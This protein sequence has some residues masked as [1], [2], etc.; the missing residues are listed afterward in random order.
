MKLPAAEVPRLDPDMSASAVE[1]LFC[2][3][4]DPAVLTEAY[5]G[6]QPLAEGRFR[7]GESLGAGAMGR[8]F[9][10]LD[11]SSAKEVAVKVMH[12]ELRKD[13]A[14]V[15][16]FRDEAMLL[17]RCAHPHVVA[18]IAA[19]EDV[20][21][22]ACY[23]AV[24]LMDDTLKTWLGR[25]IPLLRIVGWM[26]QACA[27]LS[28]AHS[29]GVIH[30]DIKASNLLLSA[31]GT[32]LKVSDFGV[33]VATLPSSP[34]NATLP[35]EP[36]LGD[37]STASAAMPT[38]T[39]DIHALGTLFY[40]LL[41]GQTPAVGS[42]RPSEVANRP[43][44]C[45]AI[46]ERATTARSSRQYATVAEMDSDLARLEADL[47]H[48]SRLWVRRS[49]AAAAGVV[50]AVSLYRLLP[51]FDANAEGAAPEALSGLQFLSNLPGA[52]LPARA[53]AAQ[54]FRTASEHHFL[55]I[56][57]VHGVLLDATEVRRCQFEKFTAS[58]DPGT[59]A[60]LIPTIYDLDGTSCRQSH[61]SWTET[62]PLPDDAASGI[63]A[64]AA[65]AYCEWLTAQEKAA[66]HLPENAF[67]RLP[68]A[69]EWLLAAGYDLAALPSRKSW[70]EQLP[71][72][73]G[74]LW[75]PPPDAANLA[76]IETERDSLRPSGWPV[77]SR[78]DPFARVA[79]A[80]SFRRDSH[81]F[82]D[83]FGNVDEWSQDQPTF[84][85]HPAPAKLKLGY[86]WMN[87][88]SNGIKQLGLHY[89]YVTSGTAGGGFRVAL[90][91]EAPA[92]PRLLVTLHRISDPSGIPNTP[93]PGKARS[94]FTRNDVVRITW[95]LQNFG[96]PATV[97]VRNSAN[98]RPYES[99][100]YEALTTYRG[101]GRS[102]NKPTVGEGVN[103]TTTIS[104]GQRQ[105]FS[106]D[107]D[108]TSWPKDSP[109]CMISATISADTP[110]QAHLETS[111]PGS[112]LPWFTDQW[113]LDAFILKDR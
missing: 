55:P 95:C 73:W 49:L 97:I 96:I 28:H 76:G 89:D 100:R 99:E 48:P 43:Q 103:Q 26:R 66:G 63:T 8:V 27:A 70:N 94:S 56:P 34:W 42:L 59:A 31:N 72:S 92:S 46:Y 13:P 90:E 38:P 110:E 9:I 30:R 111:V 68:W 88:D 36:S 58:L 47:L 67:F 82:Y 17:E 91:Y 32:T 87:G 7:L 4:T 84:T 79:P 85:E 15:E 25:P 113:W 53:T 62:C 69:D 16:R 93:D 44:R 2:D 29:L 35:S 22:G 33:A 102:D 20:F 37:A 1:K 50:L 6:G 57:G 3:Q 75:P 112:S 10:A 83:L 54:P 41:T 65:M 40:K 14:M 60:R 5:A 12:E 77:L 80:A 21:T 104:R 78:S 74:R 45:D 24:E 61:K 101:P 81:G 106:F 107:M 64:R 71:Y 109:V 108:T 105:Y 86:S 23:L 39:I 98:S 11:T 19:G 52:A 51:K 18:F